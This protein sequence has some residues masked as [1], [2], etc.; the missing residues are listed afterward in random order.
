MAWYE[1]LYS[2]GYK[3]TILWTNPS[4]TTLVTGN[5]T[6]SES[7]SNFDAI[8]VTYRHSSAD[9]TIYA[10]DMDMNEFKKANA[11]LC[12]GCMYSSTYFGF[13]GVRYISDTTVSVTSG[14]HLQGST[15]GG[16]SAHNW[17]QTIVGIKY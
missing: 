17:P 5:I 1:T 16:D 8:R 11:L 14:L 3:E 9:G 6:L 7:L 2:A 13:R 10:V 15:A 12:L 4:P